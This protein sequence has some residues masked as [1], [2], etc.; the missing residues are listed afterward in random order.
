LS[1]PPNIFFNPDIDRLYLPVENEPWMRD[2]EEH[3]ARARGRYR[4][5]VTYHH[6]PPAHLL[7]AVVDGSPSTAV[8]PT[9][10]LSQFKKCHKPASVRFLVSDLDIR[11][12]FR[13]QD[14]VWAVMQDFSNLEELIFVVPEHRFTYADLIA[15]LETMAQ[16][17]GQERERW[18]NAFRE[19]AVSWKWPDVRL[20]FRFKGGLK[21]VELEGRHD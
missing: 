20:A 18:K 19:G 1:S 14:P 15:E 21:F 5:P 4:A 6:N 8:V 10:T 9:T 7:P 11:P 17:V 16:S 13:P 2:A 12:H 3:H